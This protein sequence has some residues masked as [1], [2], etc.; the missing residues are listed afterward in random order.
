LQRW[1]NDLAQLI[2]VNSLMDK[3]FYP[4]TLNDDGRVL[5]NEKALRR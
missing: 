4:I 2:K 3:Y 1:K 5:L